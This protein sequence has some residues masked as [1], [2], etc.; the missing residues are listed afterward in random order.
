MDRS[1]FRSIAWSHV[2]K[3]LRGVAG[4]PHT[5]HKRVRFKDESTALISFVACTLH[6][7]SIGVLHG[8]NSKVFGFWIVQRRRCMPR[9]ANA[10]MMRVA[11][12]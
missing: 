8:R 3:E 7:D 5:L 11:T 10:L 9:N 4:K 1:R 12:P 6:I 2:V